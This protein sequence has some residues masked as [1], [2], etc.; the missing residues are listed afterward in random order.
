MTISVA[1]VGEICIHFCIDLYLVYTIS[2]EI[3]TFCLYTFVY[4]DLF[5]FFAVSVEIYKICLCASVYVILLLF[6]DL[7][8]FYYTFISFITICYFG[9]TYSA[10]R[11]Q[12]FFFFS[13][14]EGR[15]REKTIINLVNRDN[16]IITIRRKGMTMIKK[17]MINFLQMDFLINHRF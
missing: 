16:I 8:M 11:T 4:V 12:I 7:T 6:Y 10:V 9:M 13:N 2:D 5:V 3:Y 1:R 14:T 15:G 17:K